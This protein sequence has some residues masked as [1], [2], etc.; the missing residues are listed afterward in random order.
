MWFSRKPKSEL[1]ARLY[2]MREQPSREFVRRLERHID[3][4]TRVRGIGSRLAFAGA[5]VVFVSG[6]FASLGGLTYAET[7]ASQAIVVAKRVVADNPVRT[8]SRSS[9]SDQYGDEDE[10]EQPAGVLQPPTA[11]PPV[12]I[13]AGE[14]G[15][16]FTGAPL[17]GTALAGAA[18]IGL[19]LVLR[20]RERRSLG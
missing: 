3:S 6:A 18:L 10:E 2:A 11:P 20:R 14:E 7:G 16:P 17:F 4:A 15:L 13:A 5:L 12:D 8:V 19:G 1:E 9:A